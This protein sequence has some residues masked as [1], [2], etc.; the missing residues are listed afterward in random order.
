M[1][2]CQHKKVN[3]NQYRI[4]PFEDN[5]FLNVIFSYFLYKAPSISSSFSEEIDFNDDKLFKEF[6]NINRFKSIIFIKKNS[7]K[8]YIEH[9]LSGDYICMR[10]MRMIIT[11]SINYEDHQLESYLECVLRHIRNSIAHGLVYYMFENKR[12]YLMFEDVNLSGNISARIIVNRQT[13]INLK[14]KLIKYQSSQGEL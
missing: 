3:I 6:I 12:H 9:D 13:L 8:V 1:K 4:I 11:R 7:K 5:T 10:C 14:S 2:K